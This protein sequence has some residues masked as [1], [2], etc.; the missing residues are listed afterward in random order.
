MNWWIICISSVHKWQSNCAQH[1]PVMMSNV[2][3]GALC[4]R[5]HDVSVRG[6][7]VLLPGYQAVLVEV[8]SLELPIHVFVHPSPLSV[9]DPRLHLCLRHEAVLVVIY[10]VDQH[11]AHKTGSSKL[12]DWRRR[13]SRGD[14]SPQTNPNAG[15][16][17]RRFIV[18]TS[19]NRNFSGD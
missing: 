13:P 19:D 12:S 8:V 9:L 11:A 4:R 5:T 15:L 14:E 1:S 7:L 2:S 3:G 6:V 16:L 10:A 18:P 17:H